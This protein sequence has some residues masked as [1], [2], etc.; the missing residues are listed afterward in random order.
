MIGAGCVLAVILLMACGTGEDTRMEALSEEPSNGASAPE[1]RTPTA[2]HIL[3]R[4]MAR[5]DT[6]MAAI[7]SIF[8]P[9]PL[10]RPAQEEALRQFRYQDQL[11]RA[12]TLGVS[13]NP[14]P[15]ELE[16]LHREERLIPLEDTDYWIVRDLEYSQPLV[17]PGVR[18]LLRE[19]GERFHARLAQLDLPAYRMEV[20]SVLR[21]AED[22][23]AL[24]QVN[25][26]AV[27][28]VST[29]EY[30]TSLDVLYSAFA[31]PAA[32]VVAIEAAEASWL[33]PYLRRYAEAKAER[34]AGRRAMELKAILGEV[35]LEV[36]QEGLVMVT[37]ERRQPVFHLTL[38]HEL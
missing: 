17:V 21:A 10:L 27:Q 3:S 19:I 16:T 1:E 13:R 11:A 28:G 25:P 15:E 2:E 37:L 26:N 20:S 33:E 6:Q 32:P 18:A 31:A 8:Q 24:R 9:L 30:G 38:A 12:R 34:V 29:H 23:A 22:Q 35:L 36:Q 7:D 4:E 14:S 5:I